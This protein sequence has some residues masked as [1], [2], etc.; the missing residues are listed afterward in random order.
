MQKNADK[1]LYFKIKIRSRPPGTLLKRI[2]GVSCRHQSCRTFRYLLINFFSIQSSW[3]HAL[4]ADVGK[5]EHAN[6]AEAINTTLV[7]FPQYITEIALPGE[8]KMQN[9]LSQE[10]NNYCVLTLLIVN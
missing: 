5:N 3:G 8:Q 4:D 10:S 1:I 6:K 9:L 7:T 2:K